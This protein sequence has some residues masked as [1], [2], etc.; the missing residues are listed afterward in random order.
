MDR[1][2]GRYADHV[3]AVARIVVAFLFM[4]HGLT[5][6]FVRLAVWGRVGGQ[7]RSFQC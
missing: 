1:V 7:S 6:L 3:F 4:Q 2:L 5:K